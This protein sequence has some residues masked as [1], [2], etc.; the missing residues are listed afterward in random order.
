[1]AR[2]IQ[3]EGRA[4]FIGF[5]THANTDVILDTINSGEFDYVNLHWYFVND[6]NWPAVLAARKLDMGVSSSA[7]T[8][9]AESS[10]SRRPSSSSSVPRCPRC[11]STTSIALPGP[12]CT[13]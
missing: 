9:K 12:R 5:S 8:I 7:P 6:L 1:M 10:T 2:K 4:K 11:N 3:R 13:P